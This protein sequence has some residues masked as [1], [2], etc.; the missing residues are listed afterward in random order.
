MRRVFVLLGALAVAIGGA[1][2]VY[3]GPGHAFV[4][5]HLGDVAA[6]MLVFAVVSLVRPMASTGVRALVTLA[7]ATAIEVAQVWFHAR[8]TAANL[9]LGS[10]FD[11]IDL[12]AYVVGVGIAVGW[13]R[14]WDARPGRSGPRSGQR[15]GPRSGQR[16]G[17]W[18]ARPRA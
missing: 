9:V 18:S 11:P 12:C 4:R 5:G 10:T 3:R 17:R 1:V 8:S 16:S 15:S 7:I 6:T 2:L 14:A 13:E